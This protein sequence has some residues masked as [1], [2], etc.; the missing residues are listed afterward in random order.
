[1]KNFDCF[2]AGACLVP[3]PALL[4]L[5]LILAAGTAQSQSQAEHDRAKGAW[6]GVYASPSLRSAT[7][8]GAYSTDDGLNAW[9]VPVGSAGCAAR[10]AIE[11]GGKVAA[12]I[13][14]PLYALGRALAREQL[15][16]GSP[17][18]PH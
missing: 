7:N 16:T 8:A 10:A 1:L 5:A 15:G 12:T 13:D 2:Q 3:R 17:S 11:Y 9:K 6:A 18:K 4:S 14:N